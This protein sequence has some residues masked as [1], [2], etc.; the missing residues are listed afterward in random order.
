M[1]MIKLISFVLVILL[2]ALSLRT[3]EAS[4]PPVFYAISPFYFSRGYSVKPFN[5]IKK[6][7]PEIKQLGANVIWLQPIFLAAEPG[8][9][10]DTIDFYKINP[11]F[12]SQADFIALVKEA[13]RLGL[14]VIL[15]IALNHT[16]REHPFALDVIKNG[17]R[18]QYYD[19]YQHDPD[20]GIPYAQFFNQLKIDN[21]TFVYYFW[22]KLINL[23]YKSTQVQAYVLSVLSYWV[24]NFEVDGF[25]LDAS[26]GPSTRLP[27]FY[28]ILSEKLRG[29]KP[30]ILL[31]AEDKSNFPKAYINSGNPHL[32]SSGFDLAYDWNSEDPWWLS[33]WAFQIGDDASDTVFNSSDKNLAANEFYQSLKTGMTKASVP[34]LRYIE[35]N[36]TGSFLQFH[37]KKQTM[38]AAATMML[39]PGAPLIFYGQAEGINYAQW[40]LPALNPARPLRD[41]DPKLWDFYREILK[42]R[43]SLGEYSKVTK[44][45][46]TR[47]AQV[48]FVVDE[49]NIVI[50]DFKKSSISVNGHKLF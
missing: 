32:L 43:A 31:I 9:G 45:S 6:R 1:P 44:V 33:K 49:K 47:Q 3:A 10:Y 46:L 18:S 23:N 19:F 21:A 5:E 42:L 26:W 20:K 50:V 27:T 36:D 25:R 40:N 7:L 15:D 11:L 16:S 8:Q 41:N 24:K 2:S 13:H 22:D 28:K 38:F 12:G 39:L 14:R 17:A 30:D 35:N 48:S 29:I 37:T 34:A 4:S